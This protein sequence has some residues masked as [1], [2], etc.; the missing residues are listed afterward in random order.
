MEQILP[1][2]ASVCV[3]VLQRTLSSPSRL[4]G[5][6]EKKSKCEWK[7]FRCQ[8]YVASSSKEEQMVAYLSNTALTLSW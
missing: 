4:C 3:F 1:H 7:N 5:G 2:C 8:G 6:A